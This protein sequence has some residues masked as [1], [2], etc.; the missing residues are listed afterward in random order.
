[1]H[2]SLKISC[3]QRLKSICRFVCGHI[4]F[5]KFIAHLLRAARLRAQLRERIRYLR[6][7]LPTNE[8]LISP[9][10]NRQPLRARS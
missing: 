5:G 3:F 6:C 10:T 7:S 2:Y 1:M 4:E 9:D 8:R